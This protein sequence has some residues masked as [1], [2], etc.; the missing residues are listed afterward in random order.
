MSTHALLVVPYDYGSLS[1]LRLAEAAGRL[2]CSLLFVAADSPH[3]QE[4]LPV[5]QMAGSTINS[6]G[7]DEIDIARAVKAFAPAGIT[8]FSE[9]CIAPTARLAGLLGLPYHSLDDV[10]A[11]TCKGPQRQRL[12]DQGVESVRFAEVTRRNGIEAALAQVGLPAVVKPA[13]GAASRHTTPVYTEAECL[14]ALSAILDDGGHAVLEELLVGAAVADPWGDYLAVDCLASTEE[15]RPLFVT[16]KFALAEP[17]RERG[18]FGRASPAPDPMLD[19]AKD[20]ACAAVWALG[21]RTGIA[22][23]ELKLTRLHRHAHVRFAKRP[24]T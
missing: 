1:P 17:Y 9:G 13:S 16:S 24:R 2:D 5:L 3:A 4:M 12:R 6:A 22:D 10:G 19:A 15:V 23:V 14:R 18:G 21:I 8:T 7:M 20:L 11:I